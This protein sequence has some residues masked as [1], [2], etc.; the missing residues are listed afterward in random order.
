MTTPAPANVQ[1]LANN[2]PPARTIPPERRITRSQQIALGFLHTGALFRE[3]NGQW[4]CRAFPQ[5]YVLDAT[6]KVIERMG[7]AEMREYHGHHGQLRVCL[8]LTGAGIA[9]YAAIGGRHARRRPPPFEAE[10]ILRETEI[11]MGEMAEQEARLA[12]QLAIIDAETRETRA[13][14]KRIEERMA[15]LEAQAKSFQ[16]ERA[17]LATSRQDLRAFTAQAA[18]R[19]GAAIGEAGA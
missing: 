19:I 14:S 7:L 10:G 4:R 17:T 9:L 18:E 2:R 3:P 12:R 6:A 15:R 1:G 16:H 5:E 13:A 11:A 8:V